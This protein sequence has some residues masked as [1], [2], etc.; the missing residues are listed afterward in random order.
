MQKYVRD[1]FY[2]LYN[3]FK[4]HITA[5][6]SSEGRDR[7]FNFLDIHSLL[8][9]MS[10]HCGQH[11]LCLQGFQSL[12]CKV[13]SVNIKY[14]MIGTTHFDGRLNIVWRIFKNQV[15]TFVYIYTE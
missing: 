8:F 5:V 7:I 12:K 1:H 13:K 15:A 14:E 2:S 11:D 4:E 6:T 3:Q 9:Q 10:C